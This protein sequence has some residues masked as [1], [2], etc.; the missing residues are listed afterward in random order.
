MKAI[1]TILFSLALVLSH[2]P[3]F[4]STTKQLC[5]SATACAC[6]DATCCMKSPD[7]APA[8]LAPVPAPDNSRTQLLAAFQTVAHFVF[9][10][11]ESVAPP[12]FLP[13]PPASAAVPLYVWNCSYLI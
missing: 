6:G 13:A 1:V 4:A 8:P 2:L 10:Q 12:P 5:E 9:I 3:A 11:P 7:S